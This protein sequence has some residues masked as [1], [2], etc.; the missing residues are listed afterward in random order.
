MIYHS[1]YWNIETVTLSN[2]SQC[3]IVTVARFH[4]SFQLKAE[5]EKRFGYKFNYTNTRTGRNALVCGGGG[6]PSVKKAA[7]AE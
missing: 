3:S 6:S 1:T 2:L 5:S 4:H 7:F